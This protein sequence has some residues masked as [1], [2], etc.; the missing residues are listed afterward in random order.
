M[1]TNSSVPPKVSGASRI[2]KEV[3]FQSNVTNTSDRGCIIGGFSTLT[4]EFTRTCLF[5][6]CSSVGGLLELDVS[7]KPSATVIFQRVRCVR[8]ATA[9]HAKLQLHDD[10]SNHQGHIRRCGDVAVQCLMETHFLN[11]TCS[12]CGPITSVSPY[13]EFV[14]L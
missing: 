12:D 2:A 8:P 14:R 6:S 1:F 7:L 3:L 5:H 11:H 10:G 4:K 13:S 9:I